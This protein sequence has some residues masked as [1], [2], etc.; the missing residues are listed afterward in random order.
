MQL[1][2]IA[3]KNSWLKPLSNAVAT[4]AEGHSVKSQMRYPDAGIEIK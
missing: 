2:L 3:S 1:Q 4:R